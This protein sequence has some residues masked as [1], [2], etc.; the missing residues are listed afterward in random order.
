MP[1]DYELIP[2]GSTRGALVGAVQN[3]FTEMAPWHSAHSCLGCRNCVPL[4]DPALPLYPVLRCCVVELSPLLCVICF[5]DDKD[6]LG[7]LLL[8]LLLSV[9]CLHHLRLVN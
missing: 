9:S 5:F 3:Y 2:A 8:S 6:F 1:A 4:V 7:T